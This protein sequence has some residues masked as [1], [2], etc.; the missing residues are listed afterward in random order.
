MKRVFYLLSMVALPVFFAVS[1]SR[2]D[3]EPTPKEELLLPSKIEE[4]YYDKDGKPE[5]TTVNTFTYNGTKLVKMATVNDDDGSKSSAEYSVVLTYEGDLIKKTQG[6]GTEKT[7]EYD[8]KGN[9][10]KETYTSNNAS[11]IYTEICTYKLNGNS[12]DVA[13]S[14]EEI[15]DGKLEQKIEGTYVY[16][17][18]SDQHVMKRKGKDVTTM[19]NAVSS[20][21]YESD[22][23]EDYTYDDKNSVYR[24]FS[25]F[26]KLGYSLAAVTLLRGGVHNVLT[27]SEY[28]NNA[29][30][31]Y[32]Y[33]YTYNDK[34]FPTKI[35][36]S[37]GG[38]K[39]KVST[40]E[41]KT[42]TK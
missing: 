36:E 26:D 35:E 16:T 32:H 20:H 18:T 15:R 21:T 40:I 29:L 2:N 37:R 22:V 42:V 4:T 3:D 8:S 19:Y 12:V 5:S 13:Y 39:Y 25:G 9:L 10:L 41:Y 17:L 34:N 11:R 1:C 7:F 33:K 6:N 31:T 24:H 23:E 30:Q 14:S 28:L 27:K 38:E